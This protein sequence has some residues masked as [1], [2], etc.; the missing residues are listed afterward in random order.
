VIGAQAKP[1]Y[2]R[3]LEKLRSELGEE[4]VMDG[5]FGAM[6]DVVLINDG[7]VTI[8]LDSDE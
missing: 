4:N 2:D 6:M 5:V 1:L 7:P 8:Q 3:F